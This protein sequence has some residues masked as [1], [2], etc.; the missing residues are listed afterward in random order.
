MSRYVYVPPSLVNKGKLAYLKHNNQKF[1]GKILACGKVHTQVGAAVGAAISLADKNDISVI[2]NPLIFGALGAV[3]GKLPDLL[4]PAIN[5]HHRQFFH[6]Y[7]TMGLVG[8]GLFK[9]FE[10]EPEDGVKQFTRSLILVAGA[11]YLSHLFLDMTTPRGLR[12]LGKL[13]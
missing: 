7:T 11:A 5:P 10:W 9:A 3:A 12:V 4:E 8:F 13:S 6:S 2:N 1:R